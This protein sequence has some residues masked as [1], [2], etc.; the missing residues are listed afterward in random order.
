LKLK[1][2]IWFA[3]CLALSILAFGELWGRL[4][5]WLSPRGLQQYGVFHWGVL[6]LCF[7]WL[8]LKRKQVFSNVPMGWARPPFIVLGVCLLALSLFL[9]RSDSFLVFLMLLGYLSVFTMIFGKASVIPLILLSIYGFSVAF[10]ILMLRA[11]GEPAA[12]LVASTVTLLFN[13]FGLPVTSEGQVLQ[14]VSVTGESLSAT[15]TPGCAAFTTLGVFIALFAL[16][17]V[18]IRL[19][20][21]KMWWLFFLGLVGTWLQNIVRIVV[22]VAA[23]YLWGKDALVAMHY[24]TAYVIFPLWFALFT[25]IYLKQAGWR[26][27]SARNTDYSS[28]VAG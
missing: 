15:I 11:L 18:D 5:E 12:K 22:S 3:A 4:P 13:I 14:L 26:N 23:G 7:L 9:P 25:F 21:K 28:V 17:T 6:G 10:P 16:M 8:W 24:N 20:L 1:L 27:K 19:T 2:T